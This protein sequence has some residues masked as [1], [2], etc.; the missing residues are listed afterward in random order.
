MSNFH[1][2]KQSYQWLRAWPALTRL[3]KCMLE[4]DL[5]A[6][7]GDESTSLQPEEIPVPRACETNEPNYGLP[8]NPAPGQRWKCNPYTKTF[9]AKPTNPNR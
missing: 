1:E 3:G 6:E 7:G 4:D 2:A 9:F 5:T 8:W